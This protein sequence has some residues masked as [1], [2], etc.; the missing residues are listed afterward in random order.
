MIFSVD[1]MQA[2]RGMDIGTA[3][4]SSADR[5]EIPHE[6]IDIAEP[7]DDLSV[8]AFQRIAIERLGAHDRPIIVVGGSGLHFRSIVDPLTFAPHDPDVRTALADLEAGEAVDRLLAADPDAGAH[9]DLM[10]P[11]RVVRALE[12]FELTGLV[13]SE[14]ATTPEAVAVR[15]YRSLRPFVGI[16]VDPGDGIEARIEARVEAM[17][18]AGLM[19]E[20][21]G[22][23]GRLGRNASRAVG[24]AELLEVVDGRATLAEAV[25]AIVTNTLKLV[26]R[27]RTWFRRDPRITWLPADIDTDAAVAYCLERWRL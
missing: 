19:E 15:E 27:Q 6:L 8:E 10:N 1:S 26:R 21:A 23:A 2:Y 7:D 9:I 13:P 24:Y 3:K 16:G 17:M 5:V 18:E 12:V 20:V 4:P 22:L 25:E 11:R 14:R